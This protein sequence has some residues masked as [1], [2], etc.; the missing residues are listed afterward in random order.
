MSSCI[1]QIE[2]LSTERIRNFFHL[3]LITSRKPRP[4]TITLWQIDTDRRQLHCAEES[5]S[6]TKSVF[7]IDYFVRILH[8]NWNQVDKNHGRRVWV[9]NRIQKF[10]W[11][12][13]ALF[14]QSQSEVSINSLIPQ[15]K[16]QILYPEGYGIGVS[17]SK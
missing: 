14:K 17:A 13:S 16:I 12:Y 15:S 3:L 10:I 7:I 5:I 8:W 9:R 6:K 1:K 2:S 4:P 11:A